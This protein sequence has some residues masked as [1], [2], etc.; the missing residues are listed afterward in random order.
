MI[1]MYDDLADIRDGLTRKQR[2]I[3]YCLHQL[4]KELGGRHVPTL[5]L[6]GRVVEHIDM[7]QDELQSLLATLIDQN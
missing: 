5:M 1:F 6:Y 4:E 3:L 7:S 2:V